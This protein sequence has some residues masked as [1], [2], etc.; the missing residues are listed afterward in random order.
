MLLDTLDSTNDVAYI[1]DV[2]HVFHVLSHTQDGTASCFQD[3]GE[4]SKH[5]RLEI[6]KALVTSGPS[7]EI[8]MEHAVLEIEEQGETLKWLR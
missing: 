6:K 7:G 5:F 2:A 4:G 1:G 3:C 8:T